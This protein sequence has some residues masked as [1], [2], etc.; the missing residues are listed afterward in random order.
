M[1]ND[2]MPVE[3]A[4]YVRVSTEEQSLKGLSIESQTAD[5]IQYCKQHK[6][7]LTKIY[8]DRGI[9]ARKDLYKR[10]SFMEM[11]QDVQMHK[12]NHIVILRLDRFF[13]NVYDYHRMMNEYLIPN[14]CEWSAIKEDYDTT[15]TNGRLMI[16][17]RLSIAEQECDQD[18]DRIK[19]IFAN[20]IKEGYVCTG[21]TPLGYKIQEHRLVPNE[22]AEIVKDIFDTFLRVNSI[23]L[24][25]LEIN[26][27][28]QRNFIF[29]TIR[30]TLRK[31]IYIGSHRGN[32]NY[33]QPIVD[34][35]TFY[36]VQEN[37]SRNIYTRS[38]DRKT[39]IFSGLLIC[40]MCNHAL[41]GSSPNT[42][43]KGQ[44]PY[45]YYKCTQA[46]QNRTC[47]NRH[48][49]N[50]RKIEQQMLERLKDEIALTVINIQDE[51]KNAKKQK[52]NR[53]TIEKKISRLTDLYISEMIT[54]DE[55]KTKKSELES[56]II[57]DSPQVPKRD[58]SLL[59]ELLK[60]DIP[61]MYNNFNAQ[62]KQCFWRSIVKKITVE[63]NSVKGV[64]FF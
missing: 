20:R 4:G 12:I 7:H 60:T 58:I 26:A 55:Y 11:M 17:L 39:Y 41:V 28:H 23:R 40:G 35:K 3:A 48:N 6:Y 1:K 38:Q 46:Y 8:V 52:S 32:D 18:S 14:G 54:L 53:E 61:K 30:R 5:I 50:E 25:M 37:I 59:L 64:A 45:K 10:E 42:Y 13:R 24:T 22:D 19:D 21:K 47:E 44:T 34:K 27:R 9:T 16:N 29:D 15:T 36:A 2:N 62:E 56:Q 33:C 51:Q 31:P 57:D 49:T 63:G 43:K